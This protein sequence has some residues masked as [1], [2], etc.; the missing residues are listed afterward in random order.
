MVLVFAVALV[1]RCGWGVYRMA[2]TA[3]PTVLEFPD[4]VQY[5][6]MARSL[7]TGAGLRDELGFR[8]TRMPLFPGL[9]A[10]LTGLTYGVVVAKSVQWVLGSV[11]AVIALL[12]GRRL[13][14]RR[15]GLLTGLFVALDPFLVF[16][17]SLLLTETLFVSVLLWMWLCAVPLFARRLSR[18]GNAHPP[19][20]PL[21]KGG[22]TSSGS[23][24]LHLASDRQNA[25]DHSSMGR[26]MV[27]GVIGALAVYVRESSLGLVFSLAVFAAFVVGFRRRTLLGGAAVVVIVMIALLPWAWRNHAVTDRKSVV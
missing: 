3:D 27:L 24:A 21:E 16:F 4:E 14:D 6:E 9:L 5:W 10:P 19:M 15:V 12:L 8:A 11:G 13:F 23:G 18:G 22:G 25:A 26:W 20:S 17:S 7:W 2:T 1:A